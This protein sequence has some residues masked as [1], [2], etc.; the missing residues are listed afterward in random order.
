M[1]DLSTAIELGVDEEDF[2]F[3]SEDERRL[4]DDLHQE[5]QEFVTKV[6]PVWIAD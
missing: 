1:S 4:W 2:P 5:F 3:E 6:G